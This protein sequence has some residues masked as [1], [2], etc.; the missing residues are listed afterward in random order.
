MA[1]WHRYG[2][3][4]V[5]HC[6]SYHQSHLFPHASIFLWLIFPLFS[7]SSRTWWCSS[8]SWLPG[9]FL[10][11]PKPSW[12]SSKGKRSSWSMSFYRRRRR[13]YNSSRACLPRMPPSTPAA[14]R[15]PQGRIC[16]SR[17]A[18]VLYHRGPQLERT[19]E[20]EGQGQDAGQPVSASS[21]G[22]LPLRPWR[23]TRIQNTQRCEMKHTLRGCFSWFYGLSLGWLGPCM[24]FLCLLCPGMSGLPFE[25]KV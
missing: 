22:I 6:H 2:W 18:T 7:Y 15:S 1:Q 4:T 16:Q 8:A 24:S 25:H 20:E 12:S 9:W 21:T 14:T 3:Y 23:K 19:E 11:F 17:V 13:N 5:C 10:M